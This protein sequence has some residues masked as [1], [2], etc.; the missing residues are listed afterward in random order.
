MGSSRFGLDLDLDLSNLLENFVG[1]SRK[2][3]DAT[4]CFCNT[5]LIFGVQKYNTRKLLKL[6]KK[7][8]KKLI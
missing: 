3:E 2:L 5:L 6:M 1:K 7:I 4:R 8:L